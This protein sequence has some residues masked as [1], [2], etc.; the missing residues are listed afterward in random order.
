MF[1]STLPSLGVGRLK[2]RGDDLR[3]YGTDR[4]H[5]LRIPE[6][7]FYKQM[8][9]E[10]TK[11]QIGVDIYASSDKYCDVASLGATP[12]LLIASKPFLGNSFQIDLNVLNL[13]GTLSKYTGGQ[14]YY[15]PSFRGE[16]HHEKLRFDLSRNLTRETAWEAV[17]RVRCGKGLY[18]IP[19]SNILHLFNKAAKYV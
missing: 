10:F 19:N 12:S 15:Y 2:L 1:Q 13:T 3:I 6:D 14:L 5:L 18:L 11:Y 7:P 9:A 4:E 17:M 16:T 8:A